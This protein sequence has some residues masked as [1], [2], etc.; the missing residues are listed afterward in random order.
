L[1]PDPAYFDDAQ[2]LLI[3]FSVSNGHPTKF[4]ALAALHHVD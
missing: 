1:T 3:F 2:Y 4:P